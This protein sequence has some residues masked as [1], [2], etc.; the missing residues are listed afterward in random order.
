MKTLAK[1]TLAGAAA[2]AAVGALAV[3]L[4]SPA[5]A[6]GTAAKREIVLS[7][8]LL[9]D[10]N[11]NA[12]RAHAQAAISA[13]PKWG[14]AHAVL[15]RTFLALGDGVGAES[16]LGRA[17]ATGFDMKRGHQLLAD[18]WLIE[19]DPKRALV[20][21][22]K[23]DP[24]FGAYATRVT[25]KALAAQGKMPEAISLFAEL[26]NADPG[27]SLAW[28]DLARVRYDAGDIAGANA[29]AQ[30]AVAADPANLAALTLRGELVRDQ[31]GLA[32][33]LPW[34]EAALRHDAYYHP[35]L[36]EYA[37]TLGDLGR[38]NDMLAV[39]RRALAARPGSPQALYLEAVLAARAESYDL[40]RSLMQRTGGAI[41]DLP[42]ALLLNGTL[43][44]QAGAYEEAIGHWRELVGRQPM[45]VTARRLLG[46]ALLRS[47]DAKGALDVL[48]PVALRGDADSYTLALVGRAFEATG[49]RDWAGKFLDRSAWPA[50]Q[51]SAPFGSDDNLAVLASAAANDPGNPVAA[52]GM[53]RGLIDAGQ[54][55]N[56]LDR[57]KALA[58]ASPG[59]PAAHLLVGDT[60]MTMGRAGEAADAYRRAADIRF[61]EPTMLK[62]VDALDRAGRR[63]DGL[64]VL[65]LFLSQHPENVAALRLAAHWQIAARDWDGAIDTLEDLRSRVGSRDV[66]LLAE[67]AYANIGAGNV[68][69]ALDYGA[70]AYELAPMSPAA[71]D[72][73][74]WAFYAAGDSAKARDLL[75]K[76]VMLAPRQAALRW[77]LA[78]AYADL[79]HND[80]AKAQVAIALADP[81]FAERASAQALLKTLG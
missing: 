14:L 64:K 59:A 16:E 22:A 70:A 20:E 77:H 37:A 79:G 12:A 13:D 3:S 66:G 67:L 62:L 18:A 31:Y 10:G 5:R 27:N 7:L 39:T 1:A 35:A 19:G 63:P 43:D 40:A 28:S 6:D 51:G 61:D 69:D 54:A 55:G 4:A 65:S 73:Y 57:A 80:S 52:V 8:G 25:A 2:V 60:L 29:N 48:R 11:F 56:A 21:A 30:R 17:A 47:G 74:G 76:A 75:E 44:Y 78:Q 36:I 15:A 71:S 50:A 72:A 41:D 32:A 9:A 42:G 49:E 53:V 23:A 58:A 46:A 45:N 38:Y 26:L 34:F 81:A 24:R 68:D 33:A